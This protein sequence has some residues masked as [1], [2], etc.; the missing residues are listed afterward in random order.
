M[1]PFRLK[2]I[3]TGLYYQPHKHR[4]NNLSEKGKVY[5]TTNTPILTG[6]KKAEKSG[7]LHTRS[8]RIYITKG[9]RVHEKTKDIIRWVES[10]K[11]RH[12]LS[13]ETLFT[14]WEIEFL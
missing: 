9:I 3:P 11:E 6:Y 8:Y 5:M 12:S 7:T 2:H 14:D 4:G 10:Y 1:K 13:Y